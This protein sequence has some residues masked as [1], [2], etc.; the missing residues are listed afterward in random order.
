LTVNK[1]TGQ[2]I[3]ANSTN[4][5]A[6]IDFYRISSAGLALNPTGWNSLD[7]QNYHAVDGSDPGAIAGDSDGEGWDDAGGSNTSQLVEL[8]L[9][10]SGSAF[11]P[12][13]MLNLGNAFNPNVFGAGNNGD[14]QFTIG[15]VGGAQFTGNVVYVS[16]PAG[17]PGD[18]NSNGAVDAADYVLWRNNGP[19]QNEGVTPGTVTAEDY[20]F[21]RSRF[22]AIS[23]AGAAIS[24]V[25]EPRTIC[26]SLLFLLAARVRRHSTRS[27]D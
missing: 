14:L 5:T 17:V 26:I 2:V 9:G 3:M 19:L 22:G 13:E 6:N 20:T 4:A 27:L 24:A 15:L 1:N 21:W 16:G 11:A 7:A 23:G 8:F 18:Y 12:N 25:P 10:E